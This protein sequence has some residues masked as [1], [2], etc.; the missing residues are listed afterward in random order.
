MNNE[1]NRVRFHVILVFGTVLNFAGFNGCKLVWQLFIIIRVKTRT[2]R[3]NTYSVDP[4]ESSIVFC[5]DTGDCSMT[6]A[7]PR[8]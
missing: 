2:G 1:V 6:E 7:P 8:L 3:E 4:C 5:T